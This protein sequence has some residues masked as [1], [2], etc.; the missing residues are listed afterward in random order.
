M[1][2][3]QIWL[4]ASA[5]V[6]TL[7]LV[8]GVLVYTWFGPV[9]LRDA[10]QIRYS[11]AETTSIA[12]VA[13]ELVELG[14]IRSS[15]GLKAW[16][17]FTG[18]S[19]IPAGVYVFS[20]RM[21]VFE[22]GDVLTDG[23]DSNERTLTFIEG[24][25]IPEI[26]Q[27]IADLTDRTQT[28]VLAVIDNRTWIES[29]QADYWFLS[30][31]IFAEGIKHPLEGYLAANTY[32][33]QA[34]SSVEDI[35]I[36]LLD[37]SELVFAD[38]EVLATYFELSFHEVVTLASIVEREASEFVD[39]QMVAGVFMNRLETGMTLGSDVTVA[40]AIDKV[41]LNFTIAELQTDS[42]YNTYVITGLPVGPVGNPGSDAIEAVLTYTPNEYFYF[43]ADVCSDGTVYYGKTYDEHLA[44]R[45]LYLG[46]ID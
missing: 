18:R 1:K 10:Q 41:A 9:Q 35:V 22:V 29:L 21:L 28:D 15:T 8:I 31:E 24:A 7:L 37:Q 34:D 4:I 44:L 6:C 30:D 27:I 17:N 36:R 20:T 26:A 11:V 38:F 19:E 40:Y 5:S 2:S 33:I 43:L 32:F 13:D 42:P 12:E 14:I 16:S 3:K 46:C 23:L 25:T 45:D 39:R